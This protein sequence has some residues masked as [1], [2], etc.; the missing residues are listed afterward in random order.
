MI[1]LFK[2]T[3][4]QLLALIAVFLVVGCAARR[5]T[6]FN[7]T[8]H[9]VTAKYN[10]LFNGSESFKEGL[11][12]YDQSYTD[13]YALIL[14]VFTYGNAELASSIKSEMDRS[15]EKSS[16]AIK[17]HSITKKPEGKKSKMTEKEK[18]FY[19]KNEYNS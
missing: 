19:S 9:S 15:I 8:Y 3:I 5:N 4:F 12:K 1:R 6:A 17:L 13:N 2:K 10:I 16:K 18:Q 14:P 7:R 11:A